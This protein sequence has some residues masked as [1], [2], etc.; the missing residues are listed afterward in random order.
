MVKALL[1]ALVFCLLLLEGRAQSREFYQLKIYHVKTKAQETRVDQFL[2]NTWMPA[3]HK[4][5]IKNIGVFKRIAQDTA[6]QLIYVLTPFKSLDQFI[7][8]DSKI[9]FSDANSDY[10]NAAYNDAPYTRIESVLLRAFTGMPHMQTPALTGPKHDRVYELRSYE[11][12]TEKYYMNKVKMFNEG[13]EVGI[14]KRLGF[15]AI[16]YAGV[17]S[18]SRMPNLMYMTSF[19]D[20]ASRDAHWKAFSADEQW[21]KLRAMSEYQNN[22]SKAGILLLFPTEY[23]DY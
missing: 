14:F 9:S 11:G 16:F 1:T 22:V 21:Q 12:P 5:G 19:T 2:Q 17:L 20:Q 13:D 18:G 10:I 6:E 8:L 3:L 4:T 7:N 15:N 23:S